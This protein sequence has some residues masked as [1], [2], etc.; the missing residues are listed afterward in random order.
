MLIE[1]RIG[2]GRPALNLSKPTVMS[3]PVGLGVT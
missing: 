3:T 2:G 1:L